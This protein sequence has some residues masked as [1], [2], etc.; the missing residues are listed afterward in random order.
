MPEVI[1]CHLVSGDHDFSLEVVIPDMATYEATV[2]IALLA[3]PAI[4]VIRTSFAMRLYKYN[5]PLP[6]DSAGIPW[7]RGNSQG[8]SCVGVGVKI[9]HATMLGRNP[10]S[11]P[12]TTP[13]KSSMSR[14]PVRPKQLISFLTDTS[15]TQARRWASQAWASTPFRLAIVVAAS[16]RT[17]KFTRGHDHEPSLPR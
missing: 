17:M 9:T 1:A 5:G 2:L 12:Q 14:L 7:C 3:L 8:G 13:P 6:L 15:A 4:G 16:G 11:G 10:S